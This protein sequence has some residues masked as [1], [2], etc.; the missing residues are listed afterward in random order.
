VAESNP[1]WQSH[2]RPNPCGFLGFPHTGEGFGIFWRLRPT[3]S[4]GASNLLVSSP[5]RVLALHVPHPLGITGFIGA[6]H[7]QHDFSGF[8]TQR[9]AH[10]ITIPTITYPPVRPE[11]LSLGVVRQ[12]HHEREKRQGFTTNGR[13]G[14]LT[15]NGKLW[16]H[17]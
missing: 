15:T 14:K 7:K 9:R 11:A 6:I 12:A 8:L 2:E 10:F 4:Q 1:S 5:C 17:L 13:K 3:P 16:K